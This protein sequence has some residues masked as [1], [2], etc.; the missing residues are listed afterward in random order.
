MVACPCPNMRL[1]AIKSGQ[2]LKTACMTTPIF[3]SGVVRLAGINWHPWSDRQ[4]QGYWLRK[5]DGLGG[6]SVEEGLLAL[7]PLLH[8]SWSVYTTSSWC[9]SPSVYQRPC[10]TSDPAFSN[11]KLKIKQRYFLFLFSDRLADILLYVI[12]TSYP[13]SIYQTSEK[14][15]SH[16]LISYLSLGYLVLFT[17]LQ[18]KKMDLHTSN[19]LSSWVSTK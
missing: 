8:C 14:C 3:V 13:V 17:G 16:T 11:R 9:G 12:L 15:L 2:C 5:P 1:S 6:S 18:N 7:I 19:R 10:W 4:V